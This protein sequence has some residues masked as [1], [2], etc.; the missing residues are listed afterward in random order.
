MRKML[1][2]MRDKEKRGRKRLERDW[3]VYILRCGDGS[4]YT[5]MAK[6]VQVRLGKHRTGKG[7]A[8]TR[9]RLPLELLHEEEGFTRSEALVREAAI[10]ALSRAKKELLLG[11][12]S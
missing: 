2:V 8:Y 4:F 12:R 11:N 9:S 3:S 6:D 7:A 5:G 10:K 1:K